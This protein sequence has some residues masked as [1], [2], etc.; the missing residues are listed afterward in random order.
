MSSIEPSGLYD[1]VAATSYASTDETKPL[2]PTHLVAEVRRPLPMGT[3]ALSYSQVVSFLSP[4]CSK[5]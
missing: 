1:A 5:R 2:S 3:A 4:L